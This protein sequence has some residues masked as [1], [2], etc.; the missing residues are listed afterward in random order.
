LSV[1]TYDPV[2]GDT[3]WNSTSGE[4]CD[5]GNLLTGDGCDGSCM[6]EATWECN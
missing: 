1:C 5:D 6:I 3:F 4:Q 2:C